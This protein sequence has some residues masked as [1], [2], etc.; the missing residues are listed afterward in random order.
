MFFLLLIIIYYSKKGQ[1][2]FVTC[3]ILLSK[4]ET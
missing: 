3:P 2:I 4:D 1:I